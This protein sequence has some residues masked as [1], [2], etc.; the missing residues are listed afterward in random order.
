MITVMLRFCYVMPCSVIKSPSVNSTIK[1]ILARRSVRS[2]LDKPVP[3][4]VRYAVLE[5]AM[6]APTAG[7]LMLYTIIEVDRQSLKD[8]LAVTCDNQPFIAKAP[9]VLLFLADYQRWMD[10]FEACG[11]AGFARR[12]G[13]P[14]RKPAEGDLMLACCDALIAAQTAVLAAESIGLGSC[15]VGDIMENYELHRDLFELPS[16]VFPICLLC[17]GYPAPAASRRK[18]T[19]RFGQDFIV[20]RDKYRRLTSPELEAMFREEN[21][22]MSESAG[23][24]GASSIGQ[25][26]YRRK[27]AAPFMLEMNRSV[28]AILQNWSGE[29]V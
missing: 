11:A 29:Q 9:W 6:R 5:A 24:E 28:K 16:Y 18:P 25:L 7:N 3:A 2:Y 23:T 17:L 22:R 12:E 1:K 21:E 13:L 14:V 10:Y 8:K 19:T 26:I 4:D 20:F 15:Y 27:Y